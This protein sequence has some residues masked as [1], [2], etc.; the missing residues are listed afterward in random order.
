VE[1]NSILMVVRGLAKLLSAS[2]LQQNLLSYFLS[3]FVLLFV[4]ELDMVGDFRETEYKTF[5]CNF[6]YY[7]CIPVL[8]ISV[9]RAINAVR[10]WQDGIT[11]KIDP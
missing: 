7:F 2:K 5:S 4:C 8:S 6:P 1:I 10:C 11:P 3:F 9:S